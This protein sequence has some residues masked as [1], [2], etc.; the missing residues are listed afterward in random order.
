MFATGPAKRLECLSQVMA[1]STQPLT[2]ELSQLV[3]ALLSLLP[4]MPCLSQEKPHADNCV[5]PDSDS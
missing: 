3:K 2:H 1:G 4:L 5:A